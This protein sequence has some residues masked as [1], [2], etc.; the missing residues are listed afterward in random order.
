MARSVV[1]IGAGAGGLAA[2]IELAVAG[3]DVRVLEQKSTVGGKLQAFSAAGFRWDI[4]PVA[5]TARPY[6]ERLFRD[7]GLEMSDSLRLHRLDPMLRCFF[8]DGT[9]FDLHRDWSRLSA[10]IARL[11]PADLEGFLRFLAYAARLHGSAHAT[12]DTST[13]GSRARRRGWHLGS[14]SLRSMQGAINRHIQSPKLRQILGHFATYVGGSP[15]AAPAAFNGIAHEILSIGI[16]YPRGGYAA[17]AA[18]METLALELGVEILTDSPVERISV[19]G[20]VADGVVLAADGSFLAAD[21]VISNV[22]AAA[23]ARYLLPD[24]SLSPVV[25]NQL[26]RQEQSASAFVMMLGVRGTFPQLAHH[27]VFFSAEPKRA[28]HQLL[29]RQMMPDDPTITLSVSCRSDPHHAPANQENWLIQTSAPAL[30]EKYIWSAEQPAL[31]DRVLSIL[32]GRYGLDLRDR[33]RAERHLTPADFQRETGA[34]RGALYGP[35]PNRRRAASAQAQIGSRHIQRLYSVGGAVAPGGGLA[36]ALQ[37]GRLVVAELRA[38]T[39]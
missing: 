18:A 21:T 35:S 31:R 9:I 20:G 24:G 7:A 10:E 13:R 3:Y 16:D 12:A 11:N 30:S 8:P 37:S 17:I 34:W 33:L 32:A 29:S 23:T 38:D 19:K 2:A 25:M 14:E 28:C 22:D 15:F 26:R 5:F 27:N 1:I 39:G 36:E 4:G 6:L